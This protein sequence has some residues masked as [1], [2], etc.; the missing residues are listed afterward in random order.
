M[1]EQKIIT[2]RIHVT[3]KLVIISGPNDIYPTANINC[4]KQTNPNHRKFQILVYHYGM[5]HI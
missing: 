1:V 3:N 4:D 2:A 5:V